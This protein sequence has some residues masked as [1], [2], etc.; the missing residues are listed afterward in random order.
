[1]V[2]TTVGS[3]VGTDDTKTTGIA[4]GNNVGRSDLMGALVEEGKVVGVRVGGVNVG[5]TLLGTRVVGAADVGTKVGKTLGASVGRS[6]GTRVVGVTEAGISFFVGII[7]GR[8]VAMLGTLVAK[9]GANELGAT[10]DGK[11]EGSWLGATDW[12]ISVG[13]REVGSEVVGS[14]VVGLL[15]VGAIV[16]GTYV[17][18]ATVEGT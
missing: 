16:V 8:S 17:D 7:E 11:T 4:E 5:V 6:V 15:V 2:D 9:N 1:M 10:V 12:G 13:I 14:T 3:R 18:G